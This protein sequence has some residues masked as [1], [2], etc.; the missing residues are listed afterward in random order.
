MA[1]TC[2]RHGCSAIKEDG[3]GGESRPQWHLIRGY[4][5][6]ACSLFAIRINPIPKIRVAGQIKTRLSRKVYKQQL[7]YH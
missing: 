7:N 3:D 4:D 2:R 6:T 5:L 1:D